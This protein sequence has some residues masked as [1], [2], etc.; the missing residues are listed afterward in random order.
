MVVGNPIREEM[1]SGRMPWGNVY[2]NGGGKILKSHTQ[3]LCTQVLIGVVVTFTSKT[4]L[5]VKSTS[6]L[7]A[8]GSRANITNISTKRD[9]P[10]PR[11]VE[12]REELFLL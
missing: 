11:L 3:I 4:K 1:D 2:E 8:N 9:L 12:A 6:F 5:L 10:R 7:L